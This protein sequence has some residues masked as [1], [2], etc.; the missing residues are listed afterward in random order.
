MNCTEIDV[1]EIYN[2]NLINANLLFCG[3]L[4]IAT[5]INTSMLCTINK[6]INNIQT[7][8]KNNLIPPLYKEQV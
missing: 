7:Q 5:L 4:M 2:N 3:V 6:Q 8:I 1:Y